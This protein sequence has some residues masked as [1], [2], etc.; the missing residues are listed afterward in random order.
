[1]RLLLKLPDWITVSVVLL[2]PVVGLAVVAQQTPLAVM[3]PPPLVVMLPPEV[4]VVVAMALAAVVLPRV[5][6]TT[7]VVKLTWAP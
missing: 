3:L 2:L 6:N 5:G 1:M 7:R 4:A